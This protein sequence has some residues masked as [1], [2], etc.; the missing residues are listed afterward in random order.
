VNG[1]KRYVVSTV[2]DYHPPSQPG[3]VEI[4]CRRTFETY[5]FRAGRGRYDC[6]CIRISDYS[7]ID[8]LPANDAET[9]GANHAALVKKYAGQQKQ[10]RK[11]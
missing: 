9:A 10:E 11:R 6:G 5:V 2:G 7:E 8:S 4:G 3:P 1:R